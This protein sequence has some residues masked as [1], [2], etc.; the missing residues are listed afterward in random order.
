MVI[1][2]SE[3]F[4]TPVTVILKEVINKQRSIMQK[5]KRRR[6][7]VILLIASNFLGIVLTTMYISKN[8][9]K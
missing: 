6:K 1:L 9:K 8:N 3:V 4:N 2:I 7:R 5:Q